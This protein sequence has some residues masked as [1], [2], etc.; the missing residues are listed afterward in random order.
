VLPSSAS[1]GPVGV[2]AI[3]IV[4]I[5]VIGILTLNRTRARA[6]LALVVTG[7]DGPPG[8]VG[9]AVEPPA[10]AHAS[11]GSAGSGRPILTFTVASVVTLV[12]GVVLERSGN[13]LANNWGMNGV[14][15]GATFLAAATALPEISTGITGVR[16]QRYTLVFGDIFG[17][18]AFQLT[19]FLVADLVAGQPVLPS[20][21]KSN[22]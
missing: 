13:Q 11:E 20:E 12:A 1:I 19:L 5:W 15:F 17:G 9:T 16:R 7:G 21:G 2:G 4:V 14:V 22:A 3:G 8:P 6:D 10:T 18:N